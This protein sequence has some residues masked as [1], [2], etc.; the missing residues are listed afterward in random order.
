M[1]FTIKLIDS[2]SVILFV[3]IACGSLGV[4]GPVLKMITL[5]K[6]GMMIV[7]SYNVLTK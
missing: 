7:M 3:C 6:G 2:K 4:V 1:Q 5:R